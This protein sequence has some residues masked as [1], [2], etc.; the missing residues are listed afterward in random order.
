MP[1]DEWPQLT[2]CR[3]PQLVNKIEHVILAVDIA[4]FTVAVVG[5]LFLVGDHG[6][7]AREMLGAVLVGA[8]DLHVG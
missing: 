4:S 7:F 1:K 2:M 3:A 5:I 6:I 8:F